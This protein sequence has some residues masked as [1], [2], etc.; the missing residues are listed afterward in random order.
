MFFILFYCLLLLYDCSGFSGYSGYSGYFNSNN[1]NS[2]NF[3]SNNFNSNNFNS[4]NF[5]SNNF[6][7]GKLHYSSHM[8]TMIPSSYSQMVSL[9]TIFSISSSPLATLKPSPPN[10][11]SPSPLATLSPSTTFRSVLSFTSDIGLSNVKTVDLDLAA[12]ESIISAQ[13]LTMN[14]SSDD[15]TFVSSS[16]SKNSKLMIF[17]P[18]KNLFRSADSHSSWSMTDKVS[19]YNLLVT[20]KTVIIVNSEDP[21]IVFESLSSALNNAVTSGTFTQHLVE[22][23]VK[24]NS[25][26]TASASILSV[27]NSEPIIIS[28]LPTLSPS[29]QNEESKIVKKYNGKWIII[30]VSCISVI[31]F[32]NLVYELYARM[33]R[34]QNRSLDIAE[35]GIRIVM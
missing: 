7:S 5:N 28:P 8:L 34:K 18:T 32:L 6:N 17:K 33:R 20:T 25:S 4:N 11:L 35:I 23:S 12:Q 24:L 1:F 22:I 31:V 30:F 27:T 9:N 16:V 10:T 26:A 21:D 13:A 14:I 2:N 3:N 15:I 19:S 29:I